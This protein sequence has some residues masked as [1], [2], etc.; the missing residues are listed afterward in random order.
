MVSIED[1]IHWVFRG[2]KWSQYLRWGIILGGF[3]IKQHGLSY[4]VEAR[5]MS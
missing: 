5:M 2:V 1:G 4:D 3:L